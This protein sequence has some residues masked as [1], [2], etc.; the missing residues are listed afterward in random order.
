MFLLKSL[1]LNEQITICYDSNCCTFE[2][3]KSVI[4]FTN[5]AI[6]SY[7]DWRKILNSLPFDISIDIPGASFASS[8]NRALIFS[9]NIKL[10]FSK[11]NLHIETFGEEEDHK[12]DLVINY[13]GEEFTHA[14]LASQLLKIIPKSDEFTIKISQERSPMFIEK[15]GHSTFAMSRFYPKEN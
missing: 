3:G 14:F 1:P 13:S 8:L 7:I 4:G 5:P 12:E 10:T 2:F 11:D 6:D 15:D 9:D